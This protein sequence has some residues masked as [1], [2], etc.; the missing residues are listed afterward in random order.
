[1]AAVGAGKKQRRGGTIAIYILLTIGAFI[2]IM[3]LIW[4]LSVAF[5]GKANVQ[6]P[7]PPRLIPQELSVK[8]YI[9]SFKNIPLLMYVKNTVIYTV[10]NMIV[11]IVPAVMAGYALSKINFKGKKVAL[12]LCLATMMVPTEMLIIPMWRMFK[13]MNML[14]NYAALILPSIG[15]IWGAFLVKQFMD[16]LPDS[17]REAA[18]IDGASELTVFS[19][20]YFPLSGS[21]IATISVFAFMGSW[22]G[23]LWPLIV[24]NDSKKYLIQIGMAL[25]AANKD[26]VY[27]GM[28]MA[29]T[30][31]SIIPVAL[32]FLFLQRYIVE[33]I[34]LAGM[35]N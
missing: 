2:M 32:V 35:K 1:M 14:N 30:S 26:R 16:G 20:V 10:L 34:A 5:D 31:L 27:P 29:T 22:N 24:L 13:A 6:L 12:M 21:I 19:K 15:W 4:M 7:F 8:N 11:M 23:F 33:S 3:P 9:I 17:L 28:I 25:F 18:K